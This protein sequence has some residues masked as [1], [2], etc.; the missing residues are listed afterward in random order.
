MSSVRDCTY[1]NKYLSNSYWYL[2]ASGNEMEHLVPASK[3]VAVAVWHTPVAV[4]TVSNSWWWTERPSETCRV[5][6][7]INKFV[8]QV[9][10]VGF[11]IGIDPVTFSPYGIL[12]PTSVLFKVFKNYL[13]CPFHLQ[14][15]I[16]TEVLKLR[17]DDGLKN[18]PKHVA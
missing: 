15:E 16:V 6:L 10:L 1:R 7:K 2:L 18:K 11:T 3:Q 8:K 17:P 9:R 4:C 13:S 12:L 5:L 14:L